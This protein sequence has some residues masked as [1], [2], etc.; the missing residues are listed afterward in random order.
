MQCLQKYIDKAVSKYF[1]NLPIDQ[2]NAIVSRI[3]GAQG[4]TETN[5]KRLIDAASG[6]RCIEI[7]Y[8]NGDYAVI[9]NRIPAQRSGPGW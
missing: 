8:G 2:A 3:V 9:S 5:I 7:H 6:D 4:L 1:D